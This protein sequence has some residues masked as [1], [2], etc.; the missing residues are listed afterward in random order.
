MSSNRI[1][2][3]MCGVVVM[4]VIDLAIVNT[5]LPSIQSDLRA[6]PAD[7]QWVVVIYGIFVAGFLLLGGRLG[8]LAGHRRV[9]MAGVAVLAAA[10]LVGGLAGTLE[11]LIA[12]RAAQGLGAALA[13]PN[14]LAIISHTF[15]EGPER[16]RAMG[17][18]GAAGGSAAAFSSVLG[19]LLVQGPGWP[20]A[21]FLNVPI[22]VVLLALVARLPD[23]QARAQ[24]ARTDVGGAFALTLGMMAVAFGVHQTIEHG[25][26]AWASLA[27]LLGGVALLAG[28]VG[29]EGRAAAP[30]VPLATLRRPALV[31]ANVSTGLLWASF[32]GLIY[33]LTLFQQQVQ[34]W[35]PLASGA[36]TLPIAFLSL[37]VSAAVAPRCVNRIGAA[38]TIAL[39]LAIM[40]AGMLLLARVPEQASYVTDLAPSFVVVGLGLGLAEMAA[41]L[42]ALAGVRG[43]E[44][45]LA[46]GAVETARELGGS[47]G[48]ALLVSIA[49]GAAVDGTDA[50]HRSVLGAAVFAGLGA[51]VALVRLDRSAAGLGRACDG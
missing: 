30:L 49:L 18:F 13:A 48:L 44:A 24:R 2:A 47:L 35:S 46:G 27:P 11:A 42:A 1:L 29:H 17:I 15:A 28:F 26:L 43:D 25:W 12:A 50:F 19:G 51:A 7:L 41:P 16:N 14:A 8:D 31:W 6:D 10:S 22:G 4:T 32:L 3:L 38:R 34:G 21:F 9:L 5:A 33:Q 39:G 37:G 45:G 20:W 36:A 23:G 40:G